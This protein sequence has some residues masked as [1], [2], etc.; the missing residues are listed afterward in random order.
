V[1]TTIMHEPSAV[2][3]GD[4]FRAKACRPSSFPTGTPS[5]E[6]TPPKFDCTRTP[7]A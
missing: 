3:G 2:S 4:P 7:T 5:I 6:S 1:A